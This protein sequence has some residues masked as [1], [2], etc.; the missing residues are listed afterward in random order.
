MVSTSPCRPATCTGCSVP[1]APANQH[2]A[3]ERTVQEEVAGI[4]A[5]LR[6]TAFER[7]TRAANGRRHGAGLGLAIVRTIAEAHGGTASLASTSK[8]SVRLTLP[9]PGREDVTSG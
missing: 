6:T 3:V 7:F 1:T 8:S 5:E 9:T 4:P 2:D